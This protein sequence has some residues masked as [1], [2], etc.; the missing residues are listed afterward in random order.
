[1]YWSKKLECNI[2]PAWKG[3]PGQTLQFMEPIHKLQRKGSDENMYAQ[4]YIFLV[5][6]AWVQ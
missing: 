6:H 2:T 3:L 5:S 1:M 4:H